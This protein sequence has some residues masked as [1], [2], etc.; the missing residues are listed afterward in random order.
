MSAERTR[1]TAR[2]SQEDEIGLYLRKI[3]E[4]PLLKRQEEV[5]LG[6]RA[7]A[8]REAEARLSQESLTVEERIELRYQVFSGEEAE[9]KLVESNLR[10][11][12]SV[13]KKYL[14]RGMP[15]LDLIQEGNIGLIRAAEKYDPD[16]INPETGQPYR[17][18]TYATRWIGQVINR[19]IPSQGR[20]IRLPV[21]ASDDL[22]KIYQVIEVFEQETGGEPT[23]EEVAASTRFSL[24]K[25]QFLLETA[26]S[27]VSLQKVV[28]DG[29]AELGEFVPDEGEDVSNIVASNILKEEVSE[30][31]GKISPRERRVLTLRFGLDDGK[32]GVWSKWV[33][34]LA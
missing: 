17:F 26:K 25:V 2:V 32:K 6:R 19:A 29:D 22:K 10:L 3:K 20:T 21:H 11:V 16:K 1:E 24:K 28:G 34:N 14:G 33:E 15:F 5:D 30:L 13:A 4:I 12:V 27:L 18:S 8:G 31:L 9:T 23:K 7:K